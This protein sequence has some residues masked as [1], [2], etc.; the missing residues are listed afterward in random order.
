MRP[1]Y[2]QLTQQKLNQFLARLQ[3]IAE[4][5]N[6]AILMTNQVQSDPGVRSFM[7][8]GATGKLTHQASAM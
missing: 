7:Y 4:E 5:F 1:C 3:K 6:V 2:L 8:L